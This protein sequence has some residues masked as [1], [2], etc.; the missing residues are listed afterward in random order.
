MIALSCNEVETHNEWIKDIKA[1]GK[2]EAESKFPYPIID[3]KTRKNCKKIELMPHLLK[4]VV[5]EDFEAVNVED[6]DHGRRVMVV[7]TRVTLKKTEL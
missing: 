7:M 3:D 5:L 6:A 2:L 4:A 1:Y